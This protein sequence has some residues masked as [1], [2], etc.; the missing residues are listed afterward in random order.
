[1][2]KN[3]KGNVIVSKYQNPGNVQCQ[4]FKSE[5][6]KDDWGANHTPENNPE[7]FG[8]YFGQELDDA[9]ANATAPDTT[10]PLGE[11]IE[12]IIDEKVLAKLKENPRQLPRA[13]WETITYKVV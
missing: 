8:L 3:S 9:I 13:R 1:M 4:M 12:G 11:I 5:A 7:T 2:L 6:T 10:T